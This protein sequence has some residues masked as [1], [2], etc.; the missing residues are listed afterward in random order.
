MFSCYHFPIK[1]LRPYMPFAADIYLA[2]RKFLHNIQITVILLIK[3]DGNL[4]LIM[5]RKGHN[6]DS[7]KKLRKMSFEFTSSNLQCMQS[8]HVGVTLRWEGELLEYKSCVRMALVWVEN[9]KRCLPY[10]NDYPYNNDC[11]NT[12]KI[13]RAFALFPSTALNPYSANV[14]NMVSS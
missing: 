1:Y 8:K 7:T 2:V 6:F 10:M 3:R 5:A 11:L 12:D 9:R 13:C 14:E 4:R